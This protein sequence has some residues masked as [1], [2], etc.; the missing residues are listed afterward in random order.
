MCQQIC[1]N[2][3]RLGDGILE[4]HITRNYRQLN[5][6]NNNSSG[7]G[8]LEKF[9]LQALRFDQLDAYR[10]SVKKYLKYGWPQDSTTRRGPMAIR[11]DALFYPVPQNFSTY[12]CGQL[13]VGPQAILL[14]LLDI[15]LPFLS[16]DLPQQ[17]K[18]RNTDWSTYVPIPSGY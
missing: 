3:Q 7:T 6:E 2:R 4:A 14:A 8:H 9:L 13:E 15:P 18:M 10:A 5:Q 11:I 1:Q 12:I 17:D 16:P